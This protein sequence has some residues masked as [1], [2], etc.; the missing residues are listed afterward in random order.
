[1]KQPTKKD[2]TLSQH[3]MLRLQERHDKHLTKYTNQREF[4]KSCYELFDNR[5][6]RTNRYMN[7]TAFMIKH[8]EKYGYDHMLSMYEYKN[9]VFIIVDSVC[10]TVLDMNSHTNTRQFGR[11]LSYNTTAKK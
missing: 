8:H 6:T 5:A 9:A 7:D 10:V 3:A 11:Q 1:M 2:I 4:I